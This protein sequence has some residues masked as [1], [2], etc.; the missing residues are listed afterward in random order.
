MIHG[1]LSVPVAPG[2]LFCINASVNVVQVPILR[3][4]CLRSRELSYISAAVYT[5]FVIKEAAY[6][7]AARPRP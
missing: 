6:R 2:P 3:L 5:D 4:P 1:I 7:D